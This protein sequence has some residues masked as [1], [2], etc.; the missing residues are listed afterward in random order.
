M[1]TPLRK[2]LQISLFNLLLIAFAGI[3]LRYKI[4]FS[5][6][7]IDQKYLLHGHS[8][9]AFAGWLSQVLMVLLIAHLSEQ[10]GQ[11]CFIKYRGVLYANLVT[12]YGML[13]TFPF[14]GYGFLSIFFSTLSVFVSYQFSV[15]YW[16]DLNRMPSRRVG[17]AWFKLGLLSN[18]ISSIGPFSLAYMMATKNIPQNWYLTSIY[19][20]LHFQYNGWFLFTCMGLLCYQLFKS[21]ISEKQL[22][23]IYY[24][25]AVA[26]V[27]TFFLSLLWWPIP[28]W[29]Y[30]TV[31]IAAIA[32]LAGW[33]LLLASIRRN[34]FNLK[35]EI[36]GLT[37]WL[38]VLFG[39]ALTAKLFLQ[40][41]SVIPSLSKL[42]FGFRPIVIGYLHLVLLGVISIFVLG[43]MLALKYISITKMI[44]TGVII[45]VG[46]IFLNEIILMSQGIADINYIGIPFVD[47]LLLSTAVIMF[48][49]IF[50]L[51][52]G[53]KSARP[54]SAP[55]TNDL[56]H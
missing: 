17:N 42:A 40:A 12:A 38:F 47:Y 35:K 48:S 37:R 23:N 53:I 44:R 22:K 49:G 14:I 43:Y 39:L 6:P 55:V 30:V 4:A 26:L 34:L 18:I 25:F 28:G 32:Q 7:F 8:H 3:I 20:F 19:F 56:F 1:H 54:Y 31:V 46:G 15:M 10:T 27:P 16:K 51:N 21:G 9:F 45:F 29:L 52:V 5:L 11:N 2:W 13:L 50:I 41:G 33:W 36:S 24:L